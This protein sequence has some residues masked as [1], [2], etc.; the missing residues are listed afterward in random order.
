MMF[1]KGD[2]AKGVEV[3]GFI[4]RGMSIEGR[5]C[6]DDTVRVEGAFKGEIDARGTLVVGEGGRVEGDIKVGSAIVA[7]EVYGVLQAAS[8]VE[9]RAPGKVYGEIKTPNLIIGEGAVFD[10]KCVMVKKDTGEL[11][12]EMEY[13]E[14]I[15]PIE[16]A[17]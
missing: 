6:F 9:L 2:K 11:V 15:E 16:E 17:R 8:R 3:V 14:T 12:E 1:A 13:G 7:G 5:L 4:G 10:G